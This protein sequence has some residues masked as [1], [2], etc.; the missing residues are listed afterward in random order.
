MTCPDDNRFGPLVVGCRDDLDFTKTFQQLILSVLPNALFITIAAIRIVQL[1]RKPR[2]IGA[3]A[4]L[5]FK[6][7][8]G[9]ILLGIDCAYLFYAVNRKYGGRYPLLSVSVAVASSVMLLLHS[10][11]AHTRMSRAS[12]TITIFLFISLLCDTVQLRTHWLS[13][14]P[15]ILTALFVARTAT[16]VGFLALEAGGKSKK[17][18]IRDLSEAKEKSTLILSKAFTWW[19]NDLVRYGYGHDLTQEDLYPLDEDLAAEEVGEKFMRSYRVLQRDQGKKQKQFKVFRALI[20]ALGKNCARPILPRLFLSAFKF[21]QPFFIGSMMKNLSERTSSLPAGTSVAYVGL[22]LFIN[23]GNAM[24]TSM[25]SYYQERAV[26]DIRSSLVPAL[27]QKTLRRKT[28]SEKN[29]SVISLMNSEVSL[30][31]FGARSFHEFWVAL[32]ETTLASWLLQRRIGVAFLAPVAVILASTAGSSFVGRFA[33]KRQKEWMDVLGARV[34]LTSA[35]IPNLPSIK[36]AGLGYQVGRLVQLVREQEIKLANRFRLINTT[37][38]TFSFVP[39]IMGPIV[40]FTLA[41]GQLTMTEV[42]TSLAFINL[43]SSPMILILQTLPHV[44]AGLTSIS[45]MEEFLDSENDRGEEQSAYRDEVSDVRAG[46]VKLDNASFGWDESNLS[47]QDIHLSMSPGN[48]THVVGPVAAGKTTLCLGLLDEVK[49]RKGDITVN[50]GKQASYCNQDA[51]IIN[52]TIRENIIMF[53]PFRATL[54][55]KIVKACQLQ[56]DFET[57][58]HADETVVGSQGAALSGGQKKRISLARSLYAEPEFAILD[59]VLGGVDSHT[60]RGIA[61]EVFG[62]TGILREL[63]TTVLYVSQSTELIDLFDTAVVMKSGK[64]TWSGPP[65]ELPA[66]ERNAEALSAS[67]SS[68]TTVAADDSEEASP[69][70]DT[71]KIAVE[72][73]P[74]IP[75]GVQS[76]YSFYLAAVGPWVFTTFVVLAAIGTS[77]YV[78]STLG[79]EVW[80]S[81]EGDP[82]K[83]QFYFRA[84]WALQISCLV[85]ILAYFTY[86][87]TVMGP[88]ASSKLH[89][90]ALKTLILAP[91]DYYTTVD[92]SVA[93]GYMSQDMNVLDTQFTT[94][95]ANT[96]STLF[97][98]LFQSILIILGSPAVIYGY[99]IFM[100]ILYVLQKVFLRTSVRLRS[101][102]MEGRDPIS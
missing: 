30:I 18:N 90:G 8:T 87:L 26:T 22:I 100:T 44:V 95:A 68:S 52:G 94:A 39:M 11:L 77:T 92:S 56:T 99:P 7:V 67:S 41:R 69:Q 24:S 82:A 70:K 35:I 49:H 58:S 51:F 43:V 71:E 48:F 36:M 19:M 64:I 31:Q 80:I 10:R 34:G 6:A 1:A 98:V 27:Y 65:A 79:L 2:A 66:E 72:K 45:R 40:T 61:E 55:A 74:M 50:R 37:A 76:D 73:L 12:D 57:L 16:T 47:V 38:A 62:P 13:H 83:E 97:F 5:L 59:D 4:Q 60:A 78:F 101:L 15:R 75:P 54:Y 81:A 25:Y 102:A 63:K 86:T 85:S 33:S 9:L 93:T 91:L 14:A 17:V 32:L 89:F 21:A 28:Y 88:I 42:M 46:T 23:V 53:A 29:S 3:N 20:S 96:L 84:Y